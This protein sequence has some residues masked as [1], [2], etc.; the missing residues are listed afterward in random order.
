MVE[1]PTR[2]Y[3]LGKSAAFVLH[4]LFTPSPA[5]TIRIAITSALK[6]GLFDSHVNGL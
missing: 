1:Y 2:G 4:F 3:R 6:A 5:N